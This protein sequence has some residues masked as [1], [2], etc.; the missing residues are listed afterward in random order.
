[1][2]HEER[3]AVAMIDVTR[4]D[5]VTTHATI[6]V[7]RTDAGKYG[8]VAK[9]EG[10][11]EDEYPC[12][13]PQ[14]TMPD[15]LQAIQDSWGV[16]GW[17]LQWIGADFETTKETSPVDQYIANG[18][19]HCPHCESQDIEGLGGLEIEDSIITQEVLCHSCNKRW[20]DIYRLVDVS[21]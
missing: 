6:S 2:D 9:T 12:I 18:S 20:T 5:G 10:L 4:A 13:A 14:D 3:I 8:I 1:M 11:D 7:Y 15:A 16:P 19:V 17:G 21:L